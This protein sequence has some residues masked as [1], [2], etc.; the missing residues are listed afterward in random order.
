MSTPVPTLAAALAAIAIAIAS[1]CRADQP[2][3]D[4]A[5][6]KLKTH[7]KGS[8][9]LADEQDEL[10]AD[11]QQLV[12]E[13]TVEK[14][15]TLL[16]EV[17]ESMDD[18]TDRLEVKDTGGETIAAQTDVIEKIYE[19]AKERQKQSGSGSSP[20]GAMLEM[21]EHMMGKK[22]DGDKPGQGKKPGDKGGEGM[23]GESDAA[24]DRTAGDPDGNAEKRSVKKASGTAGRMVPAEFR[25]AFEAFNRGSEELAK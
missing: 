21:M 23:T 1:P 4:D 6:E 24:N 8:I 5:G 16:E 15:I 2:A 14:V 25:D 12:L 9:Q 19:A 3:V 11:V 13:Q 22:G 20:G 7:E 18:A 10:S 17:E